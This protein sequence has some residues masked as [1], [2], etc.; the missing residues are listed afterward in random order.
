MFSLFP[1]AGVFYKNAFVVARDATSDRRSHSQIVV[2]D[3][4]ALDKLFD[5]N[6]ADNLRR[7]CLLARSSHSCR[8]KVARGQPWG[9][10]KGGGVTEVVALMVASAKFIASAY[11][12][13]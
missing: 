12:V 3:M 4:V 10:S 2:L 11:K 9:H 8:K 5:G 1:A 13:A 7:R 6:H